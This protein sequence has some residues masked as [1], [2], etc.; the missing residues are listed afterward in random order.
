M[1]DCKKL[2]QESVTS[3]QNLLILAQECSEVVTG[4]PVTEQQVREYTEKLKSLQDSAEA[5]DKR[6]F[7]RIN[8]KTDTMITDNLLKEQKILLEE[9]YE[10]NKYLLPRIANLMEMTKSEVVNLRKGIQGISGYHS[11][12]NDGRRII[13][14]RT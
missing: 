2:I 4:G 9:L 3:Y 11:N 5:A 6:L 7:E 13:N 14:T 12:T 10:I 8:S 1:Q